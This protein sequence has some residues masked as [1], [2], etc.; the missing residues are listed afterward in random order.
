MGVGAVRDLDGGPR[1]AALRVLVV[2]DEF[3]AAMDLQYLLSREG[4]TVLGPVPSV[5]RALDLIEEDRPDAALLDVNLGGQR[6]TPLAEQLRERGIPFILVTGYQRAK[7][8]E[9]VLRQAPRLA[10]P[11]QERELV[12]EMTR[13]F[14]S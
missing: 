4:C 9:P 7:L 10:K 13:A 6:I 14:L 5:D 1:L 3:L 11:V 12:R 8:H 2:E